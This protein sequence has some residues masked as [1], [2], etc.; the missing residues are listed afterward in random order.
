M[1]KT[2]REKLAADPK[3]KA[4]AEMIEKLAYN[5]YMGSVRNVLMQKRAEEMPIGEDEAI[6]TVARMIEE[7]P[8]SVPDEIKEQFIEAVMTDPELGPAMEEEVKQAMTRKDIYKNAFAQQAYKS[9]IIKTAEDIAVA[10]TPE[11]DP[12]DPEMIQ[13]IIEMIEE[14]EGA[15]GGMAPEGLEEELAEEDLAP[16]MVAE[17]LEEDNDP[18]M[19]G[20][21]KEV[22]AMKV[23]GLVRRNLH[24]GR[25]KTA[26]AIYNRYL[27]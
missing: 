26:Q 20:D 21:S 18:I 19:D 2:A 17:A 23:A 27:K 7:D 15:A 8:D 1:D 13:A 22:V 25:V 14:E 24:V 6:E 10:N 5:E 12:V 16:E 11:G 3:A 9:Q 4:A